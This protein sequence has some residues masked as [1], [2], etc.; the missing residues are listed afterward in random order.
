MNKNEN[1]SGVYIH[2]PFCKSKC[3]YC[4]FNSYTDKGQYIERYFKALKAEIINFCD[5]LNTFKTDTIF[6]G[7]GTPSYVES[8]YIVDVI[9]LCCDRFNV[10]ENA[11]ISI[12][13]NPGTLSINKLLSYRQ[14]GIN[15]LSLGLQAWQ[16]GLLKKLGR[17]HEKDDFIQ[18]YI[19]AREAGFDN[20]NIDLIFGIPEQTMS[21]WKE[22]VIN[23]ANFEPQHISCYSLKIEEDTEYFRRMHSGEMTLMDDQLDREMYYY[24]I[25]ELKKRG[26]NHYEISNFSKTG[27]Q[28]RH[29]VVCWKA[30][31]YVGFGCGAHSYF[32]GQRYNNI[33]P[34]DEYIESVLVKGSAVEHLQFIGDGEQIS[35]YIILGLRLIEGINTLD[36]KNKFNRDIYDLF[37][38]NI[39]QLIETGL[40]EVRD[41][42]IKLTSKGLDLSNKVFVEFI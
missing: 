24:A 28:C 35:E 40:L 26:Y 13:A 3:Y 36:F 31:E 5:E 10:S 9:Q 23:T 1:I 7:G 33:L 34:V 25:N 32:G 2:I 30:M 29:N 38:H 22:S 27:Y 21:D 15:R 37:G 11:E 41:N 14:A 12:E 17:I 19:N 16:D 20:I 18:N 6:I 8:H 4:D 39:F 42:N